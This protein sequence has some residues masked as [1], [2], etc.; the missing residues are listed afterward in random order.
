MSVMSKLCY[1]EQSICIIDGLF[2]FSILA[3]N[4]I[5]IVDAKVYLEFDLPF[6]TTVSHSPVKF[7]SGI[8]L[9]CFKSS[10]DFEIQYRKVTLVSV[11]NFVRIC[12]RLPNQNQR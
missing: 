10:F 1:F 2:L 8:Y 11:P 3:L 5:I 6:D 12:Q 4:I 7:D 9:N